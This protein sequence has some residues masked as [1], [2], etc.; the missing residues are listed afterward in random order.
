MSDTKNIK[1]GK[2]VI[3]IEA[4]AVSAISDRLNEQFDGAVRSI[5]DCKGRLIILGV[6]KSGLV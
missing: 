1:I 6:G 4:Q 3:Q 5:L 2:K